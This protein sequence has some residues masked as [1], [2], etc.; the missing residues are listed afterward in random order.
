MSNKTF[1]RS[2]TALSTIALLPGQELYIT[3]VSSELH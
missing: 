2:L 1:E 3:S